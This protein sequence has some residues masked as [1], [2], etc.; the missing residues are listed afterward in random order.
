[1]TLK[2]ASEDS[3]REIRNLLNR[4]DLKIPYEFEGLVS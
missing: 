3:K 1:M 2:G 4:F